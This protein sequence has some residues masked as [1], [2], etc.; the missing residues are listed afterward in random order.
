MQNQ[1][2]PVAFT[3]VLVA[4]VKDRFREVGKAIVAEL[5]PPEE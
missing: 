2:A 5:Q 3:T 1:T 4:M